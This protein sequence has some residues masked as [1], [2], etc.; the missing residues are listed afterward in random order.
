MAE[1][2]VRRDPREPKWMRTTKGRAYDYGES[3]SSRRQK[4]L[5]RRRHINVATRG[6][7]LS[8]GEFKSVDTHNNLA[9]DT[10]SAVALLNGIARGDDIT[11]RIGRE[12]VLKSIQIH[13]RFNVATGTGV[14]QT[15]R[16]LIV[17]DRQTNGSAL[18]AAQ[19]LTSAST[20]A[21]RNLENRRR[22]K[23]LYDKRVALSASAE[24]NSRVEMDLY[25]RLRHPVTFNSGDAGTV[26]DIVTG[27]IYAVVIGSEAA[28]VTSGLIT[29]GCRIRYQDK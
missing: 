29:I 23:I 28:G 5:A 4:Y 26:A 9:A 3:V 12:V 6:L 21:F 2:V 7:Q 25:R 15:Q 14:D 1:V 24:S 13:A 27:S 8:K 16:L 19:V 10:T 17:Y 18:T 22:F 11:E 20:D